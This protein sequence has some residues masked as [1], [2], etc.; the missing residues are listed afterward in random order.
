MIKSMDP[1]ILILGFSSFFIFVVLQTI[2]FRFIDSRKVMKWL[3]YLFVLTELISA[4]FFRYFLAVYFH[5]NQKQLI[6]VLL[7][8]FLLYSGLVYLYV[9]V[10][11]GIA[12][13]SIR[14]QILSLIVAAGERGLAKEKLYRTYGRHK[15][16]AYRLE[17][18]VSSRYLT[19]SGQKY[20]V[21]SSINLFIIHTYIQML[22]RRIFNKL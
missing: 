9:G 22:L 3:L 17:R 10:F 14:I 16:I 13:T 20:W 7:Y 19:V 21:V 18:L 12:V 8:H 11:F 6:T 2:I 1:I 4:V 5:L 15:I